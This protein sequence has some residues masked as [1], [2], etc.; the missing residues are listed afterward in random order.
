MSDTDKAKQTA[1]NAEVTMMV[2]PLSLTFQYTA[3][4]APSVFL[5]HMKEGR[6]VGQRP[7]H[8]D[9]AYL[10]A[11]GSCPKR[12][13]PTTV[14]VPLSGKGMVESFTVVHIPIPGNPIQPPFVV[15]NI[16]LD[17]ISTAF[18][19][20]VSEVENDKVHIGMRVEP[21]WRPRSEWTYSME[22]ILYF[23]PNGEPSVDV[24]AMRKAHHDA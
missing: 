17:G 18:I 24:D 4:R 6:L 16:L 23:K 7:K 10:P 20:L 12:G 11:R 15:A 2:S 9:D 1:S 21:V 19:H 22:N 13:E 3:G 5:Q 8:G 14:D